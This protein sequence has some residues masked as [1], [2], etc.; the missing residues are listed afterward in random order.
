M[1]AKAIRN[2]GASVRQRLLNKARQDNRPFQELLQYYA[3]ERFLYRLSVSSFADRFILKGALLLRV[4]HAPLARPTMDIDMLCRTANAPEN[5]T[6]IIHH[7]LSVEEQEDGIIFDPESITVESI[8]EDADYEGL[9]VRF[10]G[11]LDAVR[12]TIQLDIGFGDKVYP[13]PVQE[14]LPS[15]LNFSQVKMYCYSM[16]STIA[17][18][19]EVMAKL[20]ILNSRMKD[21]YDIWMLSRQY[22]FDGSRLA[23][24]I[25]QTF[26]Q[27]GIKLVQPQEIFSRKFIEE[28]QVQ[29]TA[30]RKRIGLEFLPGDFNQ[31]VQQLEL[32]LAPVV[33]GLKEK[34]TLGD[35]WIAPDKWQGNQ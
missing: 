3:M 22:N 34:G 20:G 32:F 7:V 33:K 10:R 4:W 12:L 23:E 6:T 26:E 14:S 1:S 27:R 25:K 35:G 11:H 13:Y 9:R 21:F 8:T 30:F 24:A 19:F 2:I 15:L 17:E 31:V 29:W 16:E 28:K 18:K 5:I